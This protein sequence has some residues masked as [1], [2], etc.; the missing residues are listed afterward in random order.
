M[1]SVL[2]FWLGLGLGLFGVALTSASASCTYGLLNIPGNNI[3]ND[4]NSDN[5]NINNSSKR[6]VDN[7]IRIYSF[8]CLYFSGH[9]V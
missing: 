2:Y 6:F 9:P 7:S 4:N 3:N 8:T 5:N 1:L